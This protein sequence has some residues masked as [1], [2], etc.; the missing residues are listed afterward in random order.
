VPIQ[1]VTIVIF[2]DLPAFFIL[3]CCI[4]FSC[5][6][7]EMN[8]KIYRIEDLIPHRDRMKLVDEI[9]EVTEDQ[10][11]TVSYPNDQWPLLNNHSVD[12]LIAVELVAQT[13]AINIGMKRK[14]ETGEGRGRGWIVGIKNAEF[15]VGRIQLNT[16]LVTKARILYSQEAYSVIEG[17]VN[18]GEQLVGTVS[19]QVFRE[20]FSP[21]HGE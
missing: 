7:C 9:I 11:V 10:A 20:E 4:D 16:R 3:N 2:L 1:K 19:L 12:S 21:G 8:E 6:V 18:A 14:K 17:S 13:A 5:M 15:Y